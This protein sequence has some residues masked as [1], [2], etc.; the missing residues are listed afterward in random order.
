MVHR[1]HRAD[2]MTRLK[3]LEFAH[4]VAFTVAGLTVAAPVFSLIE[5]VH[6]TGDNQRK[7]LAHFPLSADKITARNVFEAPAP[8]D[9]QRTIFQ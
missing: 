2:V 3:D 6:L 4:H 9:L 5:N 7:T 1:H 8:H